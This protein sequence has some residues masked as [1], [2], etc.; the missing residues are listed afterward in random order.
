M[1]SCAASF[2]RCRLAAYSRASSITSDEFAKDRPQV[3]LDHI[4]VINERHLQAALAEFA[5]YH[6]RELALS[7]DRW[8]RVRQGLPT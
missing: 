1:P 4:I 7:L 3:I 5:D 6:N 8:A 2:A